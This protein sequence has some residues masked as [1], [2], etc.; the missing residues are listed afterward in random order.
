MSSYHSR[1]R[2]ALEKGSQKIAMF[3]ALGT[4]ICRQ[5]LEYTVV[6]KPEKCQVD[7]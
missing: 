5:L 4:P 2:T 1:V 3:L 7:K 6:C